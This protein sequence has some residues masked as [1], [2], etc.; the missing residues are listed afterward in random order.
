METCM[1]SIMVAC[2][3]PL[4]QIVVVKTD[5]NDRDELLYKSVGS[6]ESSLCLAEALSILEETVSSSWSRARTH[7]QGAVTG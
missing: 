4:G 6:S 3:G 1:V 7:R 5:G 2:D